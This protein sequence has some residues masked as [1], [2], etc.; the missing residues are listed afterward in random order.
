MN[1]EDDELERMRA[2]RE[3]RRNGRSP[4]SQRSESGGNSGEAFKSSYSGPKKDA[5]G[6]RQQRVSS[7]K[8]GPDKKKRMMIIAAEVLILLVLVVGAAGWYVYEKTF[9][10][11]QKIEFD[12]AEVENDELS[13]EQLEK[14][15]GYMNIA[16]FGVDSRMVGGKQNVGKGTN[17]D[18]NMICSINLDTG[19]IRLVSVFRDT[20]MNISDKNTY[21]KINAAYASGGPEQAVKALNKNLGLNIKQYA[22]FNWKAVADA[23]NILDGV[24]IELSANELSWINAYITETVQE[25]GI[26]STQLTKSGLVH[27]DGVQAV[28]Y[29]RLRLGD[30]DY[31]RTERQRIV[32]QKAFDKAKGASWAQLNNLIQ[33]IVPQLATNVTP[34]S[35]VPMARNIKNYHIGETAGFPSARGETTIGKH[36]DC[37]VPQTLESNVKE[38]HKFLFNDLDYEVPINVKEYSQR[39]ADDSGMYKEGKSIGHV[40][41]DKGVSS[42]NYI[43]KK[44]GKAAA[45]N[46]VTEAPTE[47]ST[48]ETAES[49][50]DESST[51]DST[52]DSSAESSTSDESWDPE[53]WEDE[54]WSDGPGGPGSGIRPTESQ[55]IRP[56]RPGDKPTDPAETATGPGMVPPTTAASR[57]G[58]TTA[59]TKENNNSSPEGGPGQT[60][61]A[62]P[63][64]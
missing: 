48:E 17:A 30:T 6:G 38:L 44:Q 60:I 28:A 16:C 37:V 34:T 27:M 39:I 21:N 36:G 12:E 25:T 23:I 59:A 54:E 58:T 1:Y 50:T 3:Q 35:L 32:L 52:E 7:H 33:T 24:D 22:T 64:A 41:V 15:S 43:A 2:R 56:T 53:E 55:S 51:N 47:P 42:K 63:G 10:S 49:S 14:M 62:G 61:E 9:G 5:A 13:L 8:R 57:P 26:G 20:Y 40:P 4:K 46:A 31:A 19:E 11:F 29:G 18:V 45:A